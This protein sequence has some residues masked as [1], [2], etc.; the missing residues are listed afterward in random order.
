[1]TPMNATPGGELSAA[2]GLWAPPAR[3]LRDEVRAEVQQRT[4]RPTGLRGCRLVPIKKTPVLIRHLAARWLSFSVAAPRLSQAT[5]WGTSPH[6]YVV[7]TG[8][9]PCIASLW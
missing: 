8:Q 9:P 3:A 5:I 1:M 2:G 7:D 6:A 4:Q